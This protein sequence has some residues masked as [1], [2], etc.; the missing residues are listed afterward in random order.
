VFDL[1]E[2]TASGDAAPL[3]EAYLCAEILDV[4]CNEGSARGKRHELVVSW[5]D[6]FMHMGL[7]QLPFSPCALNKPTAHLLCLTS[8]GRAT[9]SSSVMK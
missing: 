9:T 7:V 2:E 1:L 5:L 6:Q 4:V 3:A 8:G